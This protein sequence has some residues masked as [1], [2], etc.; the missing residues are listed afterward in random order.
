MKQKT[1]KRRS[2]SSDSIRKDVLLSSL[3]YSLRFTTSFNMVQ[4]G[5]LSVYYPLPEYIRGKLHW[6]T[7]GGLF[8]EYIQYTLRDVVTCSSVTE[9]LIPRLTWVETVNSETRVPKP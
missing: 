5:R 9:F 4:E 8:K 6:D 7:N 1:K 2:F 3:L